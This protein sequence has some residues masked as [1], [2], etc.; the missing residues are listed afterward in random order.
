M[1]K[2]QDKI[3]LLD[4]SCKIA[5][6]LEVSPDNITFVPLS[7]SGAPFLNS[8]ESVLKRNILLIEYKN[9]TI[10]VYNR[11]QKNAVYNSEG[12]PNKLIRK[13]GEEIPSYNFGS[14]NT[15][16]LCN[17]DIS[18]FFEHLSQNK[19]IG[20]G[21]M[22]AYNF[23]QYAVFSNAFISILYNAKKRFDIGAFANIYPSRFKRRSTFSFGI[24]FK[25][26]AFNFSSVIEE[27]VGPATNIKYLPAKG[28]QLA[29][30]FTGGIHTKLN[31][32][33]F[34]KT[35]GGIGG[36]IMRGEYQRQF[37]YFGW[38]DVVGKSCV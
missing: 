6:V 14:L 38:L 10:E 31:R 26:T 24:M 8:N 5:K 27:K 17:S 15:L 28:S 4:G 22:A 12:V 13:E 3:Y 21:V 29:T 23:N 1:V 32:N 25:Y 34:L 20:L 16:A 33:F 35:F 19:K 37:N 2:S 18:G 30:I 7:E 11:P 36:F 9:G